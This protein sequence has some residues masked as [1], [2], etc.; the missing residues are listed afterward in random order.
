MPREDQPWRKWGR[1]IPKGSPHCFGGQFLPI[2]NRGARTSGYTATRRPATRGHVGKDSPLA[3]LGTGG[4]RIPQL[5]Q[6]DDVERPGR[7]RDRGQSAER[8]RARLGA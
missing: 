7:R 8:V 2:K 5:A 1:A 3:A 6:A 4:N